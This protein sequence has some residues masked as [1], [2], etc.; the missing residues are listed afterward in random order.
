MDPDNRATAGLSSISQALR[1]LTALA[2]G[3][4]DEWLEPVSPVQGS[5]A[6]L[7][8]RVPRCRADECVLRYLRPSLGLM[9]IEIL[10]RRPWFAREVLL[11]FGAEL[12]D[13]GLE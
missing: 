5:T 4:I 1:K 11:Q 13:A 3:H 2:H 12:P 6:T 7:V 8:C 10:V 9:G